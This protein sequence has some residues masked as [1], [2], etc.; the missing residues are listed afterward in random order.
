MLIYT[1]KGLNNSLIHD[2]TNNNN[3]ALSIY[4]HAMSTYTDLLFLCFL[5]LF[6]GEKGFFRILR[7][8]DECGIEDNIVAVSGYIAP[9]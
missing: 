4:L 9:H 2:T 3:I 8:S 1:S 7:G 5:F 6:S